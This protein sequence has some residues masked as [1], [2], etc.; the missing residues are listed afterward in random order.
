MELAPAADCILEGED[1]AAGCD[2]AAEVAREGSGE[3]RV[4]SLIE[5]S[6]GWT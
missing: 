1:V 4:E 2:D 6:A 3:E 5:S